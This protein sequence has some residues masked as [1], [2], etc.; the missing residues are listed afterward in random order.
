MDDVAGLTVSVGTNPPM[1][2]SDCHMVVEVRII[3]PQDRL[4]VDCAVKL[5]LSKLIGRLSLPETSDRALKNLNS[6]VPTGSASSVPAAN[7]LVAAKAKAINP[8]NRLFVAIN[9][10]IGN[11]SEA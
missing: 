11:L 5:V 4:I 9:L 8:I 3:T 1:I 7:V 2:S 10:L 6:A